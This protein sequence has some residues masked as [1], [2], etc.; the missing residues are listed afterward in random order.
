M[1]DAVY[2]T[3]VAATGSRHASIRSDDGGSGRWQ[4]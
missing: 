2:F 3:G 1:W 4:S